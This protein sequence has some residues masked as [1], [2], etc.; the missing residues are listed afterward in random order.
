MPLDPAKAQYLPPPRGEQSNKV[1]S[2]RKDGETD[3]KRFKNILLV[4]GADTGRQAAL[5]RAVTLAKN[6]EA[7]LTVV[8][9]VDQWP[10]QA[11]QFTEVMSVSDVRDFVVQAERDRLEKLI[12]PAQQ[13]GVRAGAGCSAERRSWRSFAKCCGKSTTW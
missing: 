3:M 5:D 9:V 1:H 12:V 11:R 13:G 6:N 8:G 4:V 10:L 7:Q 2:R